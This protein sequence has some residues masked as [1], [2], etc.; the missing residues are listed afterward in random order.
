MPDVTGTDAGTDA[1]TGAGTGARTGAPP[2]A[3]APTAIVAEDEPLLADELIEQLQALWPELR[4]L[5]R[6]ADGVAALHAIERHA[7]Q[8][9]FLDIRMPRLSGLDVARKMAQRCHVAFITAFDDHAIDA[10]EA[11]AVDYVLKPFSTARLVTTVQRLKARVLDAPPDFSRMPAA[12]PGRPPLQAPAP[13]VPPGA[14]SGRFL[15]WIN[16][17]RGSTV[18]IITVDEISYFKADHKYTLVATEGG[19]SLIRKTIKELI[20][21]LDPALFRQVHRA[22]IVNLGAIE[23]ATRDSR[24]NLALRLRHRPETIAVSEAYNHLFRQM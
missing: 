4:V 9:A 7:P 3:A 13:G 24:G 5:A 10:F 22:A 16:A 1:G 18:R 17:T 6:A 19:D 23:S 11:G 21:E 8:I 20:D 12:A 2:G 14:P 15:Q